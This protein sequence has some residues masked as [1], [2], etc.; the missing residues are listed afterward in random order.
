MAGYV[1]TNENCIGCNRCISVCP[2]LTANQAVVVDGKPRI[3]VNHAQCINCGACF[4]ACEHQA[5]EYADD[6]EQFFADLQRGESISLLLAPAFLANY[7]TEYEQIL[8]G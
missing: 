4:D 1:Y 8:G 7:P 6:T 5:R 2:V 3:E